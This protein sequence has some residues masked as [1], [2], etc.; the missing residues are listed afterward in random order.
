MPRRFQGRFIS[1]ITIFLYLIPI[2]A[3]DKLFSV[4]AAER[5][6]LGRLLVINLRGR[7][8]VQRRQHQVR[9]LRRLLH[10][11]T[12]HIDINFNR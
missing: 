5:R 9:P 4:G 3:I 1:I 2:I 6:E 8:L 12:V 11:R 10:G 7:R